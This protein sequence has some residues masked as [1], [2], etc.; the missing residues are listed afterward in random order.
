M[1]IQQG[2]IQQTFF[3]N[4]NGGGKPSA[5]N[6]P[7]AAGY[8]VFLLD[9]ESKTFFIK[10]NN[11]VGIT[12]REFKYEEVAQESTPQN[13]PSNFDSS[14]YATKEDL[15][16][17]LEELKKMRGGKERDRGR[18]YENGRNRRNRND[19]PYNDE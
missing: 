10:K 2:Q 5:V 8:E 14:K 3:V 16:M 6:Y 18:R 12:L 7:V 15:N 9:E 11:G 17:I 13:M 4:L 1:N 19:K